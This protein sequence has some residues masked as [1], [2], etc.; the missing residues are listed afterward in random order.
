MVHRTDDLWVSGLGIG[1]QM[2]STFTWKLAIDCD[3]ATMYMQD[4]VSRRHPHMYYVTMGGAACYMWRL[5]L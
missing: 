4:Q 1:Q 3:H 5:D 2:R